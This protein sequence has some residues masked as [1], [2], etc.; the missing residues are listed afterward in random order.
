MSKD[1]AK[2]SLEELLQL[3]RMEEPSEAFWDQFDAQLQMR[4]EKE[5]VVGLPSLKE[6]IIRFWK[7]WMPITAT[8]A[9]AF[10][11]TF[12]YLSRS[13][14]QRFVAFQPIASSEL[15]QQSRLSINDNAPVLS[16]KSVISKKMIASHTPKCFSF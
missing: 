4:L 1:K 13:N 12:S 15:C 5:A 7:Q 3:K 16:T 8:C 14:G 11:L 10:A 9:L 6:L 2:W